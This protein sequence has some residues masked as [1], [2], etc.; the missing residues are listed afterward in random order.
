MERQHSRNMRNRPPPQTEQGKPGQVDPTLKRRDSQAKIGR[1]QRKSGHGPL[2]LALFLAL[3]IAAQQNFA[4]L[5]S[6]SDDLRGLLG[7]PP[8]SDMIS[9][10]LV[11]YS[12]SAI[13]LTLGRMMSGSDKYGGI[14]HVG[15]LAAFYA[16]YHFGHTLTDNFWAVFASGMTVLLLDSY[17][18]W[19]YCNEE[20]RK[21]R[22]FI[23]QIERKEK[24]GF[25][26]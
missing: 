19:T 22:E 6:L 21:E 4:M 2:A 18:L 12:F 10:A 13:I 14:M 1:L 26:L 20:I 17:H 8:S 3:S 16:F 11:L 24:A 9:A 25:D 5:P 15:Y 23:A 7:T